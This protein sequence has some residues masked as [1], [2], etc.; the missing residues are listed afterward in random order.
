MAIDKNKMLPGFYVNIND[1]NETTPPVVRLKD[2]YTIY[3]I[4]PEIMKSTDEFGDLEE[5][6][7]EPNNPIVISSAEDAIKTLE[8][9]NL[10]MT[11]EVRNIIRLIPNGSNIALVR[12]VKRNGD[13]PDLNS[14]ADMYEALDYAFEST[15]NLASREIIVAGLSLD[16][17]LALDP[18]KVQVK[19][20]KD[21]F[22]DFQ[23]LV[24]S[25]NA[26][27]S[28]LGIVVDKKFDLTIKGTKS[29]TSASE[30]A[31]GVHDTFEVLINDETAKIITEDGVKDFKFGAEISYTGVSG[32]KTLAVSN[33]TGELSTYL[34]IAVD[35][36]ELKI[37][38][39]KELMVKVDDDTIVK[40]KEGSFRVKPEHKSKT[41]VLEK[42]DIVK[43]SDSASL[44]RR[45]LLH[46]LKITST[47]NSC[48]TFLSPEPPKSASIK[49]IQSYV[50]K[51]AG[52]YELIR[53]HS[54]LIDS[55]GQKNDLGK[56]LSVVVGVNMYDGL[57]GLR[58]LPQAKVATISQK[59]VITKKSTTAFS[60]GD[61]IEVYTFNKMDTLVHSA[62]VEKIVVTNTNAVEITLDKEVPSEISTGLNPK[63]IM[64]VNNKDFKGTY[65]ARQYSNVCREVG[66]KRS[67]AGINFKGECQVKFSQKQLELLDSKKFCV[68]Q[69]E[70]GQT[71]GSVSRSQLMTA[72][73]NQ[74]Q[75][76]E[77]LI[78]VYTL[79]ENSKS[80]LL[81][82][83][84]ERIDDGTD[85][86]IIK[87]NVDEGAFKPAVNEYIL[88][89]YTL[90]LTLGSIKNPNGVTE[91]AL[92]M[93][94]E[95]TEIQT[96]QIIRM[97]ARIL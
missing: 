96:L 8:T 79:I 83:K 53:E 71:V 59:K 36:N 81:P 38:V 39:L 62:K 40:I 78:A 26:Y 60:V 41:E 37:D 87:T 48:Y 97:S 55:R 6:Y 9:T 51:C 91:R 95:A 45:T 18:N 47:Q 68:I 10:V 58:G 13:T 86:A 33:Q 19:E 11:R 25:V 73:D 61:R 17:M 75:R 35:S 5:T 56:F 46:N 2:V 44:L 20:L 7:I 15:E 43:L 70:H 28:T 21:Q 1:T 72:P 32:S 92:Y 30:S 94:F 89:N 22:K 16:D 31:D 4:L 12:I 34:T 67:P 66:V 88:P 14:L 80:I 76:I 54:T 24:K 65:L 3:C 63:Y 90:G 52:M 50:D 42:L 57:G 85:L 29:S 74:F 49:D 64:N 27:N 93:N 69:Q 23:E 77:T 82:Y 84:G